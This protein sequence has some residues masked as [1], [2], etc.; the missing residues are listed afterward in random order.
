MKRIHQLIAISVLLV[1]FC[2]A[3][4]SSPILW[5][6]YITDEFEAPV[7]RVDWNNNRFYGV[8]NN[9]APAL[10]TPRTPPLITV[11][12]SSDGSLVKRYALPVPAPRFQHAEYN[13]SRFATALS[14]D[15][16]TLAVGYTAKLPPNG[17]QLLEASTGSPRLEFDTPGRVFGLYF[18]PKRPELWVA[19]EGVCP[20]QAFDARTG[21]PLTPCLLKGTM[22]GAWEVGFTS[23]GH[24]WVLRQRGGVIA[25][26]SY[27]TLKRVATMRAENLISGGVN[28][29]PDGTLATGCFENLNDLIYPNS[30]FDATLNGAEVVETKTGKPKFLLPGRAYMCARFSPDGTSL[31]SYSV[32]G[33]KL[34]NAKTGKL[35]R[36]I[37][38]LGEDCLVQWK[39]SGS[40]VNFRNGL[41]ANFAPHF[42][43]D[44]RRVLSDFTTCEGSVSQIRLVSLK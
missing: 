30:T 5:K 32:D 31:I 19:S 39:E 40:S 34:W 29:N 24:L 12:R 17:V 42:S 36:T 3:E 21:K 2:V 23:N 27:P 11:R 6:T 38:E 8:S 22:D 26:L 10:N 16:R 4:A 25:V 1:Y 13:D 43:P 44:G 20:V 18:H 37:P 7:R 9:V 28:F 35:I 41:D 14:P 33:V 15:G